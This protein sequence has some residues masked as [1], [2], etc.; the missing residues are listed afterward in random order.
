MQNEYKGY[1]AVGYEFF[2]NLQCAM[3]VNSA[4]IG[5]LRPTALLMF[6]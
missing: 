4:R 3:I 1:E 6:D 2:I 5:I